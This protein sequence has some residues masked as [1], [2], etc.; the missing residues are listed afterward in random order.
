MKRGVEAYFS[1]SKK[2]KI[3]LVSKTAVSG[4]ITEND[5]SNVPCSNKKNTKCLMDT[6]DNP[7]VDNRKHL[8][9]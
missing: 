8:N 3:L 2:Q 1:A 6:F 7:V 4:D 9:C 5:H